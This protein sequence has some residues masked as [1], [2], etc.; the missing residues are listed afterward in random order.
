VSQV[1][2]GVC[3]SGEERVICAVEN[4]RTQASCKEGTTSMYV[5]CLL[6][7]VAC[8]PV[9]FSEKISPPLFM[10]EVPCRCC[11]VILSLPSLTNYQYTHTV[12][13]WV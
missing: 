3:E 4:G 7:E 5:D 8:C 12:L 11:T 9:P 1:R 10:L 13:H 6:V 2:K